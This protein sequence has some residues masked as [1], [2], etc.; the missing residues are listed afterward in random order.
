MPDVKEPVPTDPEREASLGRVALWLDADDLRW[1]ARHCCCP[2]D[3]SEE[4]RNVAPG[5][6]SG[7]MRLFTRH[8]SRRTPLLTRNRVPSVDLPVASI[9]QFLV[10]PPLTSR[11]MDHI[12]CVEAK[13]HGWTGCRTSSWTQGVL[14][15]ARKASM[16]GSGGNSGFGWM[17]EIAANLW[18][19]RRK[20]AAEDILNKE[21]PFVVIGPR[22][23]FAN[24]A[25]GYR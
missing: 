10:T 7:R 15:S 2:P 18:F 5:S 16:K 24:S 23:V 21:G 3:A 1:L 12:G 6:V 22:S 11:M 19:I 4:Q 8:V 20:R 25:V 13:F 9:L 14:V 17:V